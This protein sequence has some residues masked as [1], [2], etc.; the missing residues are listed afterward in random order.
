MLFRDPIPT[1]AARRGRVAVVSGLVGWGL[2]L[3]GSGLYLASLAQSDANLAATL[4]IFAGWVVGSSIVAFLY[5]VLFA[6]AGL[7][8]Q[9]TGAPDPGL[10]VVYAGLALNVLPMVIAAGLAGYDKF[11]PESKARPTPPPSARP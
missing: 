3:G 4:R 5:G 11:K 2:L 9:M 8:Q 6:A 10:P 7:V 1:P